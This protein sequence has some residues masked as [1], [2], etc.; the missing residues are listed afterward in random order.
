MFNFARV[1][2]S[3]DKHSRLSL[4]WK[5][6]RKP[7]GYAYFPVWVNGELL[8]VPVRCVGRKDAGWTA[9]GELKTETGSWHVEDVLTPRGNT[10]VIDRRWR[11]RGKHLGGVRLGMDLAVPF[12]KL[13]YWAIPYI[14]MNGNPGS[15]T[16]PTGLARDGK[17]WVFREERTTAPGLMTLEADGLVAGSYTEPGRSERTLSAC[18]ILP[19]K[20]GYT[21]RTFF[22]FREAPYTFLG[23]AFPGNARVPSQGLYVGGSGFANDFVVEGSAQFR[24]RFFVVLDR[25]EELCHGY[26]HVWES[27]WRNLGEA[28]APGVQ[29]TKTEKLLWKSIDYHW[30]EKGK[31]C[32]FAVRVD[33]DGNPFGGFSPFIEVGWCGPTMLL[34]WLAI[35]RA[36]RARRS[37]LA[38]RA[39]Q[40][41][42]FFVENAGRGSGAFLTHFNL[43]TMQWME[44]HVNAVQMGGAAYW[45]LKCVE[46]LRGTKLLA[47]RINVDRWANFAL[48]FCD[49]AVRTQRR[50]GAFGAHWTLEGDLVG[51]ERTM[52]VHAARAVLEAY[53][54]TGEKRYLR[55]AERGAAFYIKTCVD[56]ET[57]YGDCTD[58]LSTTTENDGAGGA[59]FL[60]DLYRVTGKERYLEKAVRAAEYCLSFMFTYNVYFPSE[61]DCGRRG[62]RTRGC[63]AISP[64]TGFVCFWF[65]LQANAFLDLWRETGERRWKEYALALIRGSFQM[66]TRRG[67][68]FGLAGHLVG[69]RAEVIPVLDTVKGPHVW[70]KGMSGYA[71]HQ[72]VWWPAA[73]NLL[74]FAVIQDRFPELLQE[75]D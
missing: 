20:N 17:P 55:A 15:K 9:S 35:R 56:R 3:K 6:I 65:T 21:L 58:L 10:L 27:A 41:A 36:I 72:P 25:A 1:R 51:F 38:E 40:A 59:D 60:V 61:T 11:Y 34:A 14:S 47:R 53:H 73:F 18:S 24:R 66:M 33:C 37:Y 39:I 13:D 57:G 45:L 74:N 19:E 5:G 49:L 75:F 29:L 48:G 71:W 69:C 26:V 68:T 22:P 46:L 23:A 44:R 42:S 8:K 16:V 30:V 12:R 7:L 62:M 43:K 67:D 70:K 32:G 50:D 54:H 64:E 28:I 52:G 4:Y 63:A 31:V 2:F